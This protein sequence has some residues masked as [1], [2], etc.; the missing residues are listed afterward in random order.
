MISSDANSVM[1]PDA[2]SALFNA[3]KKA[4]LCVSAAFSV[5]TTLFPA[6]D[7]DNAVIPTDKLS[8]RPPPGKALRTVYK[9]CYRVTCEVCKTSNVGGR[10]I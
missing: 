10:K 3:V 6:N 2:I 9:F 5:D 8:M 7:V 1:Y 4:C